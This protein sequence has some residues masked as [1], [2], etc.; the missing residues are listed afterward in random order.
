MLGNRDHDS[1]LR[2]E[3]PLTAQ[4]AAASAYDIPNG[5]T[6]GIVAVKVSTCVKYFSLMHSQFEPCET[7]SSSMPM[8]L[9][10][11]KSHGML[12]NTF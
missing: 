5:P 9:M 7:A 10:L 8:R 12:V 11:L 3:A 4:Q 6:D 2:R 1:D